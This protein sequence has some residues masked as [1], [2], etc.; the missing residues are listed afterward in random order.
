VIVAPAY[1][2][3]FICGTRAEKRRQDALRKL[4][5]GR[6]DDCVIAIGAIIVD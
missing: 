5:A 1:A 3:I 6:R 2:G 4:R